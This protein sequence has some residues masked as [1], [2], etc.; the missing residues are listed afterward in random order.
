MSPGW[1]TRAGWCL[2]VMTLALLPACV[3]QERRECFQDLRIEACRARCEAGETG[4]G[5]GMAC[6]MWAYHEPSARPR[7]YALGCG[8]G[9][10]RACSA[11]ARLETD[12]VKKRQALRNAC[13]YPERPADCVALAD[14]ETEPAARRAALEAG[15][16]AGDEVACD[17]YGPLEPDRGRRRRVFADAL[18]AARTELL[19][20]RRGARP[21]GR[22]SATECGAG[23]DALTARAS[24]DAR[25]AVVLGAA[26]T[27]RTSWGV[28][29]SA[30][31]WRSAPPPAPSTCR[32]G[33]RRTRRT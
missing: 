32:A 31:R 11:L 28:R 7:A 2:A 3:E 19:P 10:G 9:D 14:L 8:Q 25:R 21:G 30:C 1:P 29:S 24:T 18:R 22:R 6:A 27:W 13:A 20:A 23:G 5:L 33:T 4:M 12:P 15:C 16:L 26:R 17:R